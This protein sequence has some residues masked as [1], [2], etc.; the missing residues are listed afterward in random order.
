MRTRLAL[1]RMCLVRRSLCRIGCRVKDGGA[2]SVRPLQRFPK[3]FG[4]VP[5]Q[6][7]PYPPHLFS[8]L[9]AVGL[10]FGH[11]RAIRGRRTNRS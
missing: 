7:P 11:F 10:G 5:P 4:G 6:Y 1:L 9:R 2:V 8:L 3:A